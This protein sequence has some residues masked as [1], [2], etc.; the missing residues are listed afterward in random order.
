M[1]SRKT[2][3]KIGFKDLVTFAK[4]GWTPEET[5]A[6]LDRFEQV[7]DPNDPD[8]NDNEVEDEEDESDT[9]D[10]DEEDSDDEDESD[11]DDE[12]SD[13]SDNIKDDSD[14]D[15][16]LEA[17]LKKIKKLANENTRLKK[18]LAK[19]QSKNKHKDLSGNDD[20]K[21]PEDSLIDVFQQCF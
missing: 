10:E 6:L 20:K 3:E 4:A 13:E 15:D 12:G 18:E 9:G 19:V 17:N 14:E 8:V 1:A 21:S 16:S 2:K 5:N 11:G 7:G